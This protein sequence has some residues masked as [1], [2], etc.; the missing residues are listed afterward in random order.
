[1]GT[2]VTNFGKV[3]VNTGYDSVAT[4]I[5][6]TAGHGSRLPATFTYPITWWNS[7]DYADPADDP[8]R[9]IVTVTNRVTDTLTVTR[10]AEGTAASN[11]NTG[12]KTYKMV[13]GL[14]KAMWDSIFTNSLSQSFRGLSLQTHPDA[15][16]AA[17]QVRLVH[18][19]AIV[20][21]D[22]QEIATWDDLDASLAAAGAGGLDTGTEQPSTWYE[23]YAI[24]NGT[25]KNIMF[26]RAKNY[27]LDEQQ[28]TD[29]NNYILRRSTGNANLRLSQG[30]QT[31]NAGLIEFIDVRLEK[32]GTPAGGTPAYYF[33]IQANSG[34]VPSDTPLATSDK[35]DATRLCA[36]TAGWVRI[37]FRTPYSV[38]AATQYHLVM[39]GDYT[40]SDTNNVKWRADVTA[41][42]YANG[43]AAWSTSATTGGWTS[44]AADD[45]CFKIYVT[46]NDAAVMMPSGY[47][48]RALIGYAY[49]NAGSNLMEFQQRDRTAFTGGGTNWKVGNF[50]AVAGHGPLADTRAFLP[51]V[52]TIVTLTDYAS[53]STMVWYGQLSSTDM[54]NTG[55]GTSAYKGTTPITIS[56]SWLNPTDPFFVDY[57]AFTFNAQAGTHDVYINTFTW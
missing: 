29:D 4:S 10:A 35:Y 11:K 34:G 26:H 43:S 38:S 57:G 15:D 6:L 19:D 20:M 51:P 24:Y 55:A 44:V 8:N 40:A 3:T 5:V 18:A 25:T 28:T 17:A 50:A 39:H 53:A 14:T 23:L 56:V 1:M 2:P 22:G 37:P 31:T 52:S 27:F 12:G 42:A 13:L 36:G 9:E 16:K 47:T 7:T 45:F 30:F 48:Q 46:E 32:T 49:N 21:N 41:A 33:T 54:L